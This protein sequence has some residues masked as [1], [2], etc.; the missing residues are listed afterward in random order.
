MRS[1]IARVLTL[2]MMLSAFASYA[3]ARSIV[4]DIYCIQD[5]TDAGG[6]GCIKAAQNDTVLVGTVNPVVVTGFDAKPG[7]YGFFIQDLRGVNSSTAPNSGVLCYTSTTNFAST[8]GL[9]IGDR[10]V[11]RGVFKEFNTGGIFMT[12]IDGFSSTKPES[13]VVTGTATVPSPVQLSTAVLGPTDAS[14]AEKWEHVL[15]KVGPVVQNSNTLPFGEF[16][17]YDSTLTPVDTML[18]D[19]KLINPNPTWAPA[20]TR[21][22]KIVGIMS[23]ENG[24]YKLWPRNFADLVSTTYNF[25]Q[26]VTSAFA[27]DDNKVRVLFEQQVDPVTAS[28]PSKYTM[29][30]FEAVTSSVV[31]ADNQSVTLTTSPAMAGGVA[32]SV[33]VTGVKTVSG[34]N[35]TGSATQNFL[36]GITPI[37]K[38]Q[39]MKS[40]SNDSSKV[41]GSRATIRGVC[42]GGNSN[43][44]FAGTGWLEETAGGPWSGTAIFGAPSFFNKGDNVTVAGFVNEFRGKT[45]LSGILYV[46]VNST[47]NADPPAS[48]VAPAAIAAGDSANTPVNRAALSTAEQWEGVLI[49]VGPAN[50]S[51]GADTLGFGQ[52]WAFNSPDSC[53][54]DDNSALFNGSLMTSGN[55]SRATVTGICDWAFNVYRVQPRMDSDITPVIYTGIGQLD[56]A[57][58]NGRVALAV[59]RNPARGSGLV[60]FNLPVGGHATLQVYDTRGR[61]VQTIAEGRYDSGRHTATWN[62]RDAA[63]GK[64]SSG[65]Y[66]VRLITPSTT[67]NTRMVWTN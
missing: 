67:V 9:K 53:L 29:G 1:R 55:V 6:W 20:G 56:D 24:T 26:V 32:T 5:T 25:P 8:I 38:V 4:T 66:L 22:T 45:E 48:V 59:G 11:V 19:D 49:R 36:G 33:T 17:V 64:V 44:E 50:I 61:L 18:V 13:V 27:T 31:N 14:T 37:T 54:F 35:M 40:A 51:L 12:E 52:W 60:E 3:H 30:T 46:N 39:E 23:Q 58:K 7:T 28:D 43:S 42:T 34:G 21:F 2:G 47:G 62:G 16:S 65:M 10:V 63:G 15:I 57:F 41:A